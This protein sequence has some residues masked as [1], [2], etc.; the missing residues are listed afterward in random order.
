MSFSSRETR[1]MSLNSRQTLM[2]KELWRMKMMWQRN[3]HEAI[4]R[5]RKSLKDIIRFATAYCCHRFSPHNNNNDKRHSE[6][7]YRYIYTHRKKRRIVVSLLFPIYIVVSFFFIILLL[8]VFFSSSSFFSFFYLSSLL[9][10]LLSWHPFETTKWEKNILTYTS[11]PNNQFSLIMWKHCRLRSK[12]IS[13]NDQSQ[14][15]LD[16]RTMHL[17]DQA[18]D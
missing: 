14:G 1:M 13:R 15:L 9:C 16:L 11:T 6:K 4:R 8:S 12:M 7:I 3:C 10:F 17:F 2:G 5:H 18:Q